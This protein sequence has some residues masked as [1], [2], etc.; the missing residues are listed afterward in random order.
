MEEDQA[1][2]QH[3]IRD[4][5][6]MGSHMYM[7]SIFQFNMVSKHLCNK[8]FTMPQRGIDYQGGRKSSLR[9]VGYIKIMC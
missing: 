9:K 7:Q 6:V 5:G 2:H 4:N 8:C 1:S 3:C